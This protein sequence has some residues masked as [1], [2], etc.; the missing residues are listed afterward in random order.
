MGKHDEFTEVMEEGDF[1]QPGLG[2]NG[3]AVTAKG[4]RGERVGSGGRK[5]RCRVQMERRQARGKA[6]GANY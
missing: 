1:K 5:I 3:F 4:G 2:L 6:K